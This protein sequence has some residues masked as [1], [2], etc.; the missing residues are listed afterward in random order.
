MGLGAKAVLR[1]SK[2]GERLLWPDLP[3]EPPLP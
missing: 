2:G 3:E 1:L